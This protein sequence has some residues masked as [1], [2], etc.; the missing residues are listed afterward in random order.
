MGVEEAVAVGATV[1]VGVRVAVGVGVGVVVGVTVGLGVGVVVGSTENQRRAVVSYLKKSNSC[2]ATFNSPLSE[3]CVQSG[4]MS[5]GSQT[6]PSD[7]GFR[8]SIHK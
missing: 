7:R 8:P 4:A 1:P 3:G 6:R 2:S 5:S